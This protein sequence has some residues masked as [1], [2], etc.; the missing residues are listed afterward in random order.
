MLSQYL[1]P[2][3]VA[4]AVG[5]L[6]GIRTDSAASRMFVIVCTGAA[7]LTI[8]STEFYKVVNYPWLGDPG[9]LSAQVI[10]ALGFLGTGLIWVSENQ[11]V[12]GLSVAASLWL[13]AILGILIG[14]GLD[15]V[16]IVIIVFLVSAY[17]ISGKIIKWDKK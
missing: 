6:M 10:V 5:A 4:A 17:L 7:L 13:T 16:S 8:V 14:T 11:E 9:R 12:K 1:L 3:I 2:I 15:L